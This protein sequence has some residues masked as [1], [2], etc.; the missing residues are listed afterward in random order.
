[1]TIL[2][3]PPVARPVRVGLVAAALPALGGCPAAGP[4]YA[5]P[6]VPLPS[7]FRDAVAAAPTR[8]APSAASVA[9]VRLRRA[10]PDPAPECSLR[11]ELGMRFL[12]QIQPDSTALIPGA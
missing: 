4:D 3:P 6:S 7:A 11:G 9:D 12:L 10:C 8:A 5:R 1:M 2:V